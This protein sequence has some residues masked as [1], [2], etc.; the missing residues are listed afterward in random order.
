MPQYVEVNG[1]IVEFPDGMSDDQIAQAI[2]GQGAPMPTPSVANALAPKPKGVHPTSLGEYGRLL[3][4]MGE[5]AVTAATGLAS[6]IPAGLGGLAAAAVPGGQTGA[7]KVDEIRSAL[8]YQPRLQEGQQ[9]A[10]ALSGP[11]EAAS[12][13]I[14]NAFDVNPG[15]NPIEPFTAGGD[16]SRSL[17]PDS[18]APVVSTALSTG[19]QLAPAAK[20]FKAARGTP[21]QPGPTT[22]QLY[23]RGSHYFGQAR[24]LGGDISSAAKDRLTYNVNTLIDS[25]GL[26]LR[27]NPKLHPQSAALREEIIKTMSK[28]SVSFDDLIELRQ[29]AGDV[30]GAAEKGE[31]LRGL[32]IKN[33]IDDY[34]DSLGADDMIGGNPQAAAE[35]LNAARQHWAA[36]S[37]ASVIEE[38]IALAGDR[39]G[40]FSGS[41]FENALRTEF[42]QL[43]RRITKGQERGFTPEEVA[44][45]DAVANGDSVQKVMTLIGKLAPTGVVS[46]GIGAGAGFA[47]A[48][49]GGAVALPAMGALSR[50]LATQRRINSA[51]AALEA[52]QN[53]GLLAP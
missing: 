9:I 14:T 46:G 32:M 7:E 48:G 53:R 13:G 6:L 31:R 3:G 21:R 1:E 45:I 37:K 41:G 49:P 50:Q 33:Q 20:A 18:L 10:G 17:I 8:T 35:S 22:S 27:I 4:G 16:F 19:A 2:R 42:R 11:L 5:N 51:N 23:Q 43:K 26:P 30:A 29:I 28:D 52:V 40:Q 38:R 36:A 44:L 47:I 34:V 24:R 15:G 39:A 25:N 12:V